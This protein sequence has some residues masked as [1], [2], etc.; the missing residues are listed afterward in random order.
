M[1]NKLITLD[2]VA[3]LEKSL[4]ASKMNPPAIEPTDSPLTLITSKRFRILIL[5]LLGSHFATRTFE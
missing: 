5:R 3:M 4:V 1:V 2:V